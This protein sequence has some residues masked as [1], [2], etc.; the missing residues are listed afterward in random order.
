MSNV[1]ALVGA[2]KRKKYITITKMYK[3]LT[4]SMNVRSRII[5][6][7]LMNNK[8]TTSV[9][10]LLRDRSNRHSHI[11]LKEGALAVF[12]F[13]RGPYGNTEPVTCQI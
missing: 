6:L 5:G 9:L 1:G 11:L 12:I 2:W 13:L 7:L 10:S 3:P 4:Q 8:Q